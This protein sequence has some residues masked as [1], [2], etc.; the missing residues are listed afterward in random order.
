M[1]T[2]PSGNDPSRAAASRTGQANVAGGIASANTGVGNPIGGVNPGSIFSAR[3]NQGSNIGIPTRGTPILPRTCTASRRRG[4]ARARAW[5]SLRRLCPLGSVQGG[6]LGPAPL[7]TQDPGDVTPAPPLSFAG[8]SGYITET[9]DL[10]SMTV[11][12]I[13]GKRSGP[14][15]YT[16][17]EQYSESPIGE[18]VYDPEQTGGGADFGFSYN[19]HGGMAPGM[20]GTERFQKL[21]SFEYLSRYFTN[22]LWTRGILLDVG[23]GGLAGGIAAGGKLGGDLEDPARRPPYYA[24]GLPRMAVHAA[25]KRTAHRADGLAG[26]DDLAEKLYESRLGNMKDIGKHMGLPDSD[27]ANAPEIRQGSIFARDV[28]RFSAAKGF[29]ITFSPAR[30]R[31][32]RRASVRTQRP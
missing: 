9:E 24:S 11:A 17:K 29:P 14:V 22:Y 19:M 23:L 1:A 16:P 12:F 15:S 5:L 21:C 32:R 7:P 2:I 18:G 27:A 8:R 10:R 30:R 28:G 20:P 13:L 26:A 31:R 6:G 25:D 3:N 4:Y